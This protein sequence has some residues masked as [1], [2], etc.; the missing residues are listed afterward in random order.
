[1]SEDSAA[2]HRAKQTIRNLVLSLI[3]CL[4]IVVFTVL[5]VPRDETSRIQHVDYKAVAA[6]AQASTGLNILVPNLPA[7][8]WCNKAEWRGK[9][10]DGVQT[11]YLGLI[12]PDNKYVGL[13]QAFNTNAT[14]F[15][16]QLGDGAAALAP[17]YAGN[18]WWQWDAAPQHDPMQTKDHV[19]TF[20]TKS[21]ETAKGSVVMLYGAESLKDFHTIAQAI[22]FKVMVPSDTNWGN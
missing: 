17:K 15:V 8:W 16:G 10:A 5:A 4:G 6:E 12:S 7:G 13:T 9:S 2:K 1:M 22:P 21:I 20:G 14:W 19:W 11:W 18:G 3:A